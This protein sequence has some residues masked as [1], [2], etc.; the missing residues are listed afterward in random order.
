MGIDLA[1]TRF[2][3]HCA[4]AQGLAGPMLAL[5]S[6]TLRESD[7]TLEAYARRHGYARL[8]L[9]KSPAALFADRYGISEYLSCDINHQADIQLDLS[10]PLPKEHRERYGSIVNGGTLE[11]VFDLR[12]AME[13]IHDATAPGGLMIHTCPLTWFDHGF[14]NINPVMFHLAAEANQYEVVLEG[15]YFSPGTW[16]G[17]VAPVVGLLG[18]DEVAPGSQINLRTGFR[19]KSLPAFVMHLIALRKRAAAPFR[20][21]VQRS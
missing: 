3:D 1:L 6:L 21:P 5:G 18:V 14:V 17:Q 20:Q 12:Q 13:N 7:D 4:E 16:E 19:G 11:H 10:V 9:E 2:F 15:Y 8:A